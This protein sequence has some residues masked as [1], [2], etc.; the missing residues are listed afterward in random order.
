MDVTLDPLEELDSAYVMI[1]KV[2]YRTLRRTYWF[3]VHTMNLSAENDALASEGTL[4]PLG[5]S[6][7][8][9]DERD[10]TPEEVAKGA[11]EI[12]EDFSKRMLDLAAHLSEDEDEDDEDHA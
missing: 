10:A 7:K 12:V 9:L 5:R 6:F 4:R 11:P 3:T 8:I 2:D 1:R